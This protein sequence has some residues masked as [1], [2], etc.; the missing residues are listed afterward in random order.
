MHCPFC[1]NTL[2]PSARI[3]YNC[4]HEFRPQLDYKDLEG[5]GCLG[6]ISFIFG[7]LIALFVCWLI[8]GPN[9]FHILF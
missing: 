2:S 7:F 8:L 9:F 6:A 3:C 4:G 5:H 1:G